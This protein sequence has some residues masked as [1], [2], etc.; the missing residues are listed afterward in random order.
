VI[1]S[2]VML[3]TAGCGLLFNGVNLL[4]LSKCHKPSAHSDGQK[5]TSIRAAIIHLLGDSIQSLGVFIAAGIIYM[6]PNLTVFD[7]LL[8]FAFAL[9]VISTTVET[10]RKSMRVLMEFTPGKVNL[11]LI[12]QTLEA[13]GQVKDIHV[14]S[15]TDRQICLSLILLIQKD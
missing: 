8:T 12:S 1:D 15:I 13:Y 6:W 5:S 4:V 11:R 10:F 3:A 7:P 14:W 9:V 2:K